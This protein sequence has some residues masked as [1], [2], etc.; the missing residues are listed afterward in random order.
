MDGLTPAYP[1]TKAE[2]KQEVPLPWTGHLPLSCP[3]DPVTR[4]TVH[5]EP[6]PSL[7]IFF[8]H[9]L[10]GSARSWA[11]V[12]QRLGGKARCVA[13]DLLGFGAAAESEGQPVAEMAAAVREVVRAQAPRRWALVGHSMG[14]KVAAVVTRQAEDGVT[15][16]SGLERI[17]LMAGSPPGPEP[18]DETQRADM[19]GW[20]AGDEGKSGA[21]ANGYITQNVSAALSPAAHALAVQDVL[22]AHTAA[23]RAWLTAGSREDWSERVG[24]LQTPALVIAGADDVHLGPDGQA[25]HTLPHYANVRLVTLPGAKHLLPG[26]QPDEIARLIAG[27]CGLLALGVDADTLAL[28]QSDRVSART[29]AA[30]LDRA[31]PDDTAYQPSA[32]SADNLVLLRAVL[33]RVLPQ[34]PGP[35]IDL[36][37]RLDAALAGGTGDG[38]R[39]ADLPP[40]A[41]AYRTGLAALDAAA[42]AGSGRGF[43]ALEDH[44]QDSLLTRAAAGDLATEGGLS[45]RQMRRWFEDVRAEAVKL[46][47]AYPATMARIGYDGFAYGGDGDRLQGFH[48]LEPGDREAWEPVPA[49]AGSR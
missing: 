25:R 20:F 12:E 6:T 35:A 32:M 5:P 16:L 9:F 4:I 39:F 2:E 23:W 49:M 30:L 42:Q 47:V 13:I 46:Y 38:W 37:A 10:G 33:A 7:T 31:A 17:V 28:I 27:H 1:V 36:A 26:E 3:I 22:R 43:A 45:G 14:A 11:A 21:E 41:E 48:A 24:V 8:L 19:L 34:G 18:M 29:R 15:G 44:A 40:D